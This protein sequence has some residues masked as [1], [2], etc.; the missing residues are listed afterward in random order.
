MKNKIA[1]CFI[2]LFLIQV[3]LLYADEQS[4]V[5]NHSSKILGINSDEFT[6]EKFPGGVGNRVYL[7]NSSSGDQFVAKIF[8]KKTLDEVQQIEETVTGLLKA[9]FFVPETLA[10]SL[11]EDTFPLHISKFQ[12]GPHIRD[13]QLQE[14]AKLMAKLHTTTLSLNSFP[15]ERYKEDSHFQNLFN[16]CSQ[17]ELTDQLKEIY[18]ELDL[19]YLPKIPKG[20][21]HGDFSYTN[22][23]TS[24]EDKLVLLDFDHLCVSYLL[25]DLV[26]CHMFYGFDENGC[27]LEEKVRDFASSYQSIRCLTSEEID[28][29]Y[30]HM[31]LMMIDTA[32]EMHYHLNIAKDLHLEVIQREEN[33]TLMPELLV[34]KIKS[35]R[36]KKRITLSNNTQPKTPIIFF[37]MSGVGKTTMIKTLLSE[38][39]DLFYI[40]VFTCTRSPRKDDDV[41]QF[42]YVTIDKFLKLDEEGAFLFTMHEG[43]RYYGYRKSNLT[44]QTRHPLLNCSPY[45]IENIKDLEAI[46]VLVQ[47]EWEKGLLNRDSPSDLQHR[48]LVNEKVLR[49][50]YS[51]DW[52]LNRMTIIHFN[53]WPKADKSACELKEKLLKAMNEQEDERT[54]DKAA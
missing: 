23:I 33:R 2:F 16:K 12:K 48:T 6:I 43:N 7:L 53:Q 47:G 3:G 5:I 36:N 9:S 14:A 27:L 54:F 10:I 42:E 25:T 19:S 49:D 44:D 15:E 11:F 46:L 20:L 26:R 37:G 8:T 29:F 50:F 45:G 38:R 30:S 17:W 28:N 34:K 24:P 18:E 4:S 41:S 1:F 32:L 21:I 39:P 35:L 51:Q 40:P 52:F 13:E 22:L 31:K